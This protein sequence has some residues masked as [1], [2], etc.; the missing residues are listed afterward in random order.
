MGARKRRLRLGFSPR[1]SSAIYVTRNKK[2]WNKQEAKS[3]GS[4]SCDRFP[5][6][7]QQVV[8]GFEIGGF[9]YSTDGHGASRSD[10]TDDK[11]IDHSHGFTSSTHGNFE[12]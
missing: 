8:R 11:I 5:H 10:S 3:P 2:L 9:T 7:E 12:D 1:W 4:E 6:D